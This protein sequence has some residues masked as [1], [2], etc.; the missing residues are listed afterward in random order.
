M[1][2]IGLDFLFSAC[3][4]LFVYLNWKTMWIKIAKINIETKSGEIEMMIFE[5]LKTNFIAAC[6]MRATEIVGID[7]NK[8]A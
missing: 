2:E 3:C 7:I 5:C 1:Y 6:E 8:Q 4:K